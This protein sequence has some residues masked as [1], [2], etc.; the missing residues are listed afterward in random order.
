M[1]D[2]W[3]QVVLEESATMSFCYPSKCNGNNTIPLEPLRNMKKSPFRIGK[4]RALNL[5]R[6]A[7]IFHFENKSMSSR[8]SATI[9]LSQEITL[10]GKRKDIERFGRHSVISIRVLPRV[11]F[12]AS[13]K[14]FA[15]MFTMFPESFE[16]EQCLRC[17]T[18]QN[19]SSSSPECLEWTGGRPLACSYW[20]LFLLYAV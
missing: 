3:V 14:D 2:E 11:F 7:I 18:S 9:S 12:F 10:R 13:S 20:N 8:A 6:P 15:S 4:M 16:R 17:S 19:P 1:L 5:G